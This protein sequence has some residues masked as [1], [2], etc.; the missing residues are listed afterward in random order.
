MYLA[1]RLTTFVKHNKNLVHLDLS[2]TGLPELVVRTIGISLRR[3]RSIQALHLCGNP[4]VTQECIEF[5]ATRVKC[6]RP[7]RQVIISEKSENEYQPPA[8]DSLDRVAAFLIDKNV[9]YNRYN[10]RFS[11]IRSSKWCRH[12][13]TIK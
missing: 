1:S 6:L 2:H 5:L 12:S 7:P 8:F 11:F 4:G 13:R 3:A 9:S 10:K